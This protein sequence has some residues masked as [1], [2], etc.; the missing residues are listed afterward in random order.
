[1]NKRLINYI[2][3]LNIQ[4]KALPWALLEQALKQH[5][6]KIRYQNQR[7]EYYCQNDKYNITYFKQHHYGKVPHTWFTHKQLQQP[8]ITIH[9]YRCYPINHNL[10]LQEQRDR[11]ADQMANNILLIIKANYGI[12]TNYQYPDHVLGYLTYQ[13]H[14][15]LPNLLNNRNDINNQFKKALT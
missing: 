2:K 1:M 14:G 6:I 15:L 8:L 10:V 9:N 13:K 3:T 11:F 12:V 5:H 4:Y 7:I